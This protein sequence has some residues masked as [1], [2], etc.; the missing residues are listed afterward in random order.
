MWIVLVSRAVLSRAFISRFLPILQVNQ[1]FALAARGVSMPCVV[2]T[3]K[4]ETRHA[5]RWSPGRT[6]I[7]QAC[8]SSPAA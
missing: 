3:I 8:R 4:R 1:P 2:G 5:R 7:I 6:V